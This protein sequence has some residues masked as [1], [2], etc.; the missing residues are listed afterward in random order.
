MRAR[1]ERTNIS[2]SLITA[3]STANCRR[4]KT[5]KATHMLLE[6]M[7]YE[8]KS[9]KW[10]RRTRARG[11]K[12][13]ERVLTVIICC[14]RFEHKLCSMCARRNWPIDRRKTS[15]WLLF[16]LVQSSVLYKRFRVW[17]TNAKI[18]FKF[19]FRIECARGDDMIRFLFIRSLIV[20]DSDSDEIIFSF[21]RIK[22]RTPCVSG[23]KYKVT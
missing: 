2:V 4:G 21:K 18:A 9:Y 16:P 12:E 1:L 13:V 20:S 10:N 14:I 15:D 11:E 8:W 5:S 23:S 22:H 6:F 7:C 17:I 3:V 19:I